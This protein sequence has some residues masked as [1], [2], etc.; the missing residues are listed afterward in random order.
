MSNSVPEK[1][2]I[3]G[4]V[5]VRTDLYYLAPP[6]TFVSSLSMTARALPPSKYMQRKLT[7]TMKNDN[8]ATRAKRFP[9]HASVRYRAADSADWYEGRTENMSCS[10]ALIAGRHRVVE[11]A[12]VEMLMPLPQQMSGTATVQVLCRGNVVRTA[13]PAIPILRSKFAVRWREMRLVNGEHLTLRPTAVS[14]DW[15]ALVHDLYNELAVIVG[16]SELLL[17]TNEHRRQQRVNI[18]K[19][20]SSRAVRLLNRLTLVLRKLH[21]HA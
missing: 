6:C 3:I 18:I 2:R 19:E 7:P 16:S 20:A 4:R 1:L 8:E 14:E 17:D 9:I 12:P 10:G 21:P 11:Q 13:V 15:H 5:T